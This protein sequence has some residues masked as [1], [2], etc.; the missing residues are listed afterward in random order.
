MLGAGSGSKLVRP[1]AATCH[2]THSVHI[3]PPLHKPILNL[4]SF[5]F[6]LRRARSVRLLQDLSDISAAHKP[7]LA[8]A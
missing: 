4:Q 2:Q 7:P 3:T 1:E 8:N 5:L 6:G